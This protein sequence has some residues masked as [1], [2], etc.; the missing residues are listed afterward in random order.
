MPTLI[1]NSTD[2]PFIRMSPETRA[3]ILGNRQIRFIE[4]TDGGHCAFIG[5]QDGVDGRWAERKLIEF[6]R[7]FSVANR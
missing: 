5:E 4:T 1:I 6:V 3:K 7:E 2:D